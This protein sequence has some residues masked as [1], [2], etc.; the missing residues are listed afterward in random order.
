M[1]IVKSIDYS[2]ASLKRPLKMRRFSGH[3]RDVVGLS[4]DLLFGR[5]LLHTISKVRYEYSFMFSL[6]V[7]K[8]SF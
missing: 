4:T 7:N 8:P 1:F 5:N 6:K 3:L 2:R